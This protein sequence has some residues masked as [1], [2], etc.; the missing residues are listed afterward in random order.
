MLNVDA[1][2]TTLSSATRRTTWRSWLLSWELYLILLVASFLRFYL[3]NTTEFDQDQAI[4][5]RMARDALFHGLLP[6]TSNTA[7]IG[8]AHSAGV[9]YLF[10]LPALLSAN[11]IG[12][13][14]LVGIFSMVAVL[15]TYFF[16]RCYY[17]R[18]AGT[19]AALLYATAARPLIYARFI[20]QPNL[21]APFVLLFLFT[22]FW[23]VVRRRKGW[24]FPALLLLGVLY[25]MHEIALL[26][27]IPLLVAVALAPGTFRWRDLAWAFA[28]LLIIFFPYLLWE[29]FTR[30]SDL[31][32]ILMLAKR[33][34]Y[35]NG[36]A[37]HFYLLFLLPYDQPPTDIHSL[38]LSL[39]AALSWLRVVVPLLTVLGLVVIGA[40]VVAPE[41]QDTAGENTTRC[42][43]VHVLRR[44]WTVL[45]ANPYKCG[46]VVLLVW[47]IVPLLVLSRH[48]IDLHSQYFLMFMPGPFIVVGL[49]GAKAAEWSPRRRGW[50]RVVRFDMYLLIAI[51]I[52]AQLVG[53]VAW[54]VDMGYGHFDSDA[55]QPYHNDLAS[56]R[57]ALTEADSLAQQ[58]HLSRVYITTDEAT[59]TSLR[60][61][62]EQVHT[63]TTLFDASHCLVLPSPADGPA[64]LLVGPHDELTNALVRQFAVSTLVDMPARLGGAPFRLYV[65]SSVPQQAPYVDAFVHDLQLLREQ[66][67]SLHIGNTSWAVTQW[68]FMRSESSRLRTTYGYVM[69]VFVKGSQ[70]RSASS[71]CTFTSM[72]AGD[73][74]L[75]AFDQ[76]AAHSV[77]SSSTVQAQSFTQ[78]PYNPSYTLFHLE[79]DSDQSTPWITLRTTRGND[80][81]N[82]Q[83]ED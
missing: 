26:L 41:K 71:I 49:L 48:S 14:I 60:Y 82:L 75:V 22:L 31:H 73:Q 66:V 67:Q 52:V 74:L 64:V 4:I 25:Q 62:S 13:A 9:I 38:L 1:V 40:Q 12:G 47:Q 50:R 55:F 79:T 59:Q 3:I 37:I 57:H 61:L 54:V 17:G 43:S 8:I 44:W 19:V 24:L 72:R 51:I 65:V 20:W 80:R 39:T 7:S 32:T 30:F 23:G 11:P 2:T 78:T 76:H 34:V 46:L 6:T 81:I 28:L 16:T 70:T 77:F 27:A 5:F 36:Q 29:S 15:L 58:R 56:L 83:P 45:R 35:L 21:M 10:M 68:G 18:V 33:P 42:A 63:P 69:T 53:S